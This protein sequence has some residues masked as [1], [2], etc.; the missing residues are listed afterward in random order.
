MLVLNK[1]RYPRVDRLTRIDEETQRTR[2]TPL[3]LGENKEDGGF[4]LVKMKRMV[5]L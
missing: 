4:T 5:D 2:D 1:H 3:K